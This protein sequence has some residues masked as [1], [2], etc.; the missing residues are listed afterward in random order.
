M[1]LI[2]DILLVIFTLIRGMVLIL[3]LIIF[4]ARRYFY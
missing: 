4:Q 2:Y 1:D 3:V